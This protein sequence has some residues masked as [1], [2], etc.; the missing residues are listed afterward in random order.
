MKKKIFARKHD[1]VS[2]LLHR[3]KDERAMETE[4]SNTVGAI[5]WSRRSEENVNAV[6]DFS[7]EQFYYCPQTK[8]EI[9]VRTSI[10]YC[11]ISSSLFTTSW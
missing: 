10:D 7:G 5:T 9:I 6:S 8:I 1:R 2:Q 4:K 11:G 3:E